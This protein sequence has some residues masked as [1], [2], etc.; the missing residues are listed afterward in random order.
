VTHGANPFFINQAA[1]SGT[2]RA[3]PTLGTQD[4]TFEKPAILADL[5]KGSS[6]Q[7]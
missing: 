7:T 6:G 3:L 5:L 2:A 4:G 1:V